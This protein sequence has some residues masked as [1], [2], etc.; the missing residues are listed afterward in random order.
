MVTDSQR[1]AVKEMLVKQLRLRM[2]PSEIADDTP[3][4]QDGLG[5]DSVDAIELVAAIEQEFGVVVASETEAQQVLV[6]VSTLT[7]YVV[8]KGGLA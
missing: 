4:F 8:E 5:L 7:D 2:D 1:L 6:N 3:F